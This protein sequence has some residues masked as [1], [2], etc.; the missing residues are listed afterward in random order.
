MDDNSPWSGRATG[1]ADHVEFTVPYASLDTFAREFRYS[2][3]MIISFPDGNENPWNASLVGTNF[4]VD[5]F[6]DCMRTIRG[7]DA[8]SQPY[9]ATPP[10]PTQPTQPFG[11][12]PQP[13]QAPAAPPMFGGRQP[14]PEPPPAPAPAPAPA[15]RI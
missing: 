2:S 13:Q 15:N 3:A 10:P 7:E 4:M 12:S 6:V 14:E 8:P 11:G 9:S 5:R 1:I